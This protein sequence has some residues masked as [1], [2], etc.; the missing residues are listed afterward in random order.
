MNEQLSRELFQVRMVTDFFVS[1]YAQLEVPDRKVYLDAIEKYG[2]KAVSM[3]KWMAI[4]DGVF[5]LKMFVRDG[6]TRTCAMCTKFMSSPSD[7]N[8]CANCPI[9]K[10]TGAAICFRTPYPAYSHSD[11]WADMASSA[12]DMVDFLANMSYEDAP[13]FDWEVSARDSTWFTI[14]IYKHGV[15]FATLPD[16]TKSR[17]DAVIVAR[18]LC[19]WY[20]RQ[21]KQ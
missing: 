14:T 12:Q 9:Y 2:A 10:E 16:Y 17:F 5:S 3:A 21:Y 20:T 18:E 13:S 4:K 11:D 8:P 15:K 6:G 1:Q 7:V 19:A